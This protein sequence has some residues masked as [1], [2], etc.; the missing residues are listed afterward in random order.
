MLKL[1]IS[2]VWTYFPNYGRFFWKYYWD[3]KKIVA[4]SIFS[5]IHIEYLFRV[6]KLCSQ[7]EKK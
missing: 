6:E 1:A 3:D 4:A 7:L 2:F 5:F